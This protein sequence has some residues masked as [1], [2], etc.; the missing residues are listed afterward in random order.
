MAA[1]DISLTKYLYSVLKK[2][3]YRHLKSMRPFPSRICVHLLSKLVV[4][5][6]TWIYVYLLIIFLLCHSFV[7]QIIS[8]NGAYTYLEGPQP[9]SGL[10]SADRGEGEEELLRRPQGDV[11]LRLLSLLNPGHLLKIFQIRVR[12]LSDNYI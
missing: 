4:F 5:R 3:G 6:R 1:T 8:F 11:R 2:L 12:L 7:G 10:D 9:E